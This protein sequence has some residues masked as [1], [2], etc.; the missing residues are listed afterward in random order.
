MM[1]W[2]AF[3]FFFMVASVL[4]ELR[5][6]K[7]WVKGCNAIRFHLA[8][9]MV[10]LAV[11]GFFL[12]EKPYVF[13][14]ILI[15]WALFHFRKIY[16]FTPFH[17]KEIAKLKTQKKIITFLTAN[18]RMSNR[19]TDKLIAIIKK[20][21]PDLI[22][23]TE[24]DTFWVD[25]MKVLDKEYPNQVLQPQDNTYGMTLYSKLPLKDW[26]I[27]YL[28]EKDVP[29]IHALVKFDDQIIQFI[30]LHPRPPAP[31]ND[32]EAKDME[33]IVAAGMTNW[34]RFPTV[35]SGD[36]ND[37]G[38]SKITQQFKSISGLLDPRVGRGFYNTYNALIPIFRIPI[39][40]FFV[41]KHFKLVEMRRLG[42][43]GSDH[44][45][46]LLKVVTNSQRS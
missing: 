33:L 5:L 38:W 39:D 46:V 2:Y 41:S 19:R 28:V 32:E 16:P 13:I 12:P 27:Q 20:Y 36:L 10:L 1:L 9:F 25:K 45:P 42:H 7:W 3:S 37:V 11:I 8:F 4:A 15:G 29:S 26:K 24:A 23:L 30:G 31:W 34:N 21:N 43:F 14:V 35:V 6:R 17:K 40:H 22:L 18:V 44:F